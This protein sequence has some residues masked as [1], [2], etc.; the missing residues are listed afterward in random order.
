MKPPTDC[1][2]LDVLAQSTDTNRPTRHLRQARFVPDGLS[3]ET[4]PL[5]ATLVEYGL[6]V[7]P[8]M[9]HPRVAVPATEAFVDDRSDPRTKPETSRQESLFPT[10]DSAQQTLDG[11][12]ASLQFL[13]EE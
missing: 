2:N 8:W 11:E 4:L 12:S 7:A 9:P 13:F 10:S 1:A 5:E 3:I 6:R